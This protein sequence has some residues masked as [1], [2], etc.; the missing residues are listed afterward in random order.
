MGNI[1]Y[2]ALRARKAISPRVS[3]VH[4]LFS[5]M[6]SQA[7]RHSYE[8]LRVVKINTYALVFHWEGTNET[9]LPLLLTAHMGTLSY[10]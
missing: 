5:Y 1:R 6:C 4:V 3:Y 2:H 7:Q 10:V 8:T 9:L